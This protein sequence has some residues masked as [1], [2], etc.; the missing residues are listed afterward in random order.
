MVLVGFY[1]LVL[2]KLTFHA[3]NRL[4]L[5]AIIPI[6]IFLPIIEFGFEPEVLAEQ[7]FAPL[8][9][10]VPDL[11]NESVWL[12]DT[13]EVASTTSQVNYIA[14]VYWL[15]VCICL[16]RFVLQFR[17]I[18]QLK[19]QSIS[20][21]FENVQLYFTDVPEVFSWFRWVFIPKSS[22]VS[23]NPIVLKHEQAHSKLGH[24]ADLLVTELL[25]I[26]LWFNPFVYF[27]HRALKIVHEY[28]ADAWALEGEIKKS[29]YLTL[30]LEEVKEKQL[31]FSSYFHSTMIK[32]RVQMIFKNKSRHSHLF[33]YALVLPLMI[34]LAVSLLPREDTSSLPT[35]A[36]GARVPSFSAIMLTENLFREESS[37]PA[38]CPIE[39]EKLTRMSSG[40]GKRIHPIYKVA[41]FHY[42]V[43]FAAPLGTPIRATADGIVEKVVES[44]EGYGNHVIVNHGNGYHTRYAQMENMHV[45]VGQPVKMYEVI[46]TVGASGYATAPHLHY[47]VSYKNKRVDPALFIKEDRC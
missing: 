5:L 15:G 23:P 21:A 47:E 4:F 28:Q 34:I 22:Q 44:S 33:K 31:S 10:Y 7:T 39:K 9:Q 17:Q 25:K 1:H 38:I 20:Q 41:K 45:K 27:F 8:V 19:R 43:D 14:I 35:V 13:E 40:F 42:G 36:V 29:D 26:W 6:S 46:G 16:I 30:L 12:E 24:S 2:R 18:L 37:T 32:S 11:T 3:L